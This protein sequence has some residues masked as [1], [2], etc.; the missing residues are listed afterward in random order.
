MN[1]SFILSIAILISFGNK[2]S[3]QLSVYVSEEEGIFG[4]S[5]D[6]A[7]GQ[8]ERHKKAQ[9]DCLK[10]GGKNPTWMFE[11]NDNDQVG[12]RGQFG[13]YALIY[14]T[15]AKG[16]RH[17]GMSHMRKTKEE[18]LQL[19]KWIINQSVQ[20][21]SIVIVLND[22]F[23]KGN[24]VSSGGQVLQTE[25]KWSDWITD[26]CFTSIEYRYQGKDVYDLNHQYHY[27]FEIINHYNVPVFFD[28]NLLDKDGK[29]RFGNRRS[30]SPGKTV[31]FNHKMTDNYITSFSIEKFCLKT[32]DSQYRECDNNN[33][34][35]SSSMED[36]VKRYVDLSCKQ[37]ELTK[38]AQTDPT[39]KNFINDM[40]P[41]T[42]QKSIIFDSLA[43]AYKGAQYLK[44]NK[45]INDGLNKC[46]VKF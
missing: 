6:S 15:D 39:Y 44:V 27:Y 45:L 28:F 35:K 13:C 10:K 4:W 38:R 42:S 23:R 25:S 24:T 11:G 7:N 1:K 22:C 20:P 26:K 21:E 32:D 3:A 30:V 43:A 5:V 14:G 17:F 19:A 40:G 9:A 12:Q 41:L 37:N 8:L 18:A 2:L 34:N 29:V 36:M 16:K 31:Q 33:G 46:P